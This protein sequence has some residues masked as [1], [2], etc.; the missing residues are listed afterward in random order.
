HFI[1]GRNAPSHRRD[2]DF[3]TRAGTAGG[4]NERPD[5]ALLFVWSVCRVTGIGQRAALEKNLRHNWKAVVIFANDQRP[6]GLGIDC[7]DGGRRSPRPGDAPLKGSATASL[8]SARD[9]QEVYAAN[10]TAS[11][12]PRILTVC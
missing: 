2:G 10:F 1:S 3:Q 9:D 6:R 12:W 4:G 11:L 8:D 5:R 7:G